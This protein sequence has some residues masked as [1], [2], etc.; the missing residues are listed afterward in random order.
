ML[1]GLFCAAY[2]VRLWGEFSTIMAGTGL[3]DHELT[4]RLVPYT[5][6]SLFQPGTPDLVMRGALVLG[7]LASL[8]LALGWR[9]RGC[10][11][12]AW[13]VAVSA[14]RWFFLVIDIDDTMPQLFL[15]WTL[16]LPVGRTLSWPQYR[17][18]ADRAGLWSQW[19]AERVSGVALR[20]FLGNLVLLYLVAGLTKS[21]SPMWR[22]GF[23]LYCSLKLPLTR[24]ASYWQPS[25][26]AFLRPLDFLTL[27][28]E[29]T[30]LP[31]MLALPSGSRLKYCGLLIQIAFHVS[32]AVLVGLPF[33]NLGLLLPLVL[34]FREE[35]MVAA[36][37]PR[38]ATDTTIGESLPQELAYSRV[39]GPGEWGAVALLVLITLA[40]GSGLPVLGA[41]YEAS[42]VLLWMGGTQ[43][44]YHV[45][46]WIDTFNLDV[47]NEVVVERDGTRVSVPVSEF[48]P[49]D[50]R[51]SLLQCY[52]HDLDWILLPP[53]TE[54]ELRR[55]VLRR[56]ASRWAL[57]HAGESGKC[58]VYSREQR[59]TPQQPVMTPGPGMQL[60]SFHFRG[61]VA[62]CVE[63]Y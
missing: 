30:C 40:Q 4:A 55:S 56:L 1:V 60:L 27:L 51:C 16:L 12:T 63:P 24:F 33:A 41:A 32:I 45:F 22:E 3:L 38:L 48:L 26:L 43:Q 2:F 50:V 5:R 19:C 54:T 58:Y 18:A 42:C 39:R 57:R 9:V 14:A 34:V 53:G 29:P 17:R 10:A 7:L 47:R 21:L 36:T 11:L 62:E 23:G 59:L 49:R 37:P 13:I 6:A 52:L 44:D 35:L 8:G 20:C 28:L 61:G 31:L 46:N 15:V 25:H